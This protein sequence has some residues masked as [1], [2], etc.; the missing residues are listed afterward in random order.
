METTLVIRE[1]ISLLFQA[2]STTSSL[3][4]KY[5]LSVLGDVLKLEQNTALA[6]VK[7]TAWS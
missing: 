6:Y 7:E 4:R 3:D 1:N 5:F 2:L